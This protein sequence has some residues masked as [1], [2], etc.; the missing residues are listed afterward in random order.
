MPCTAMAACS[1]FAP[2]RTAAGPAAAVTRDASG[3]A[4]DRHPRPRNARRGSRSR[5]RSAR[6]AKPW[7]PRRIRLQ[8]RRD[9]AR[10]AISPCPGSA[11][12]R[13]RGWPSRAKTAPAR[14]SCWTGGAA[15][16]SAGI[17]SAAA[18][19]ERAAAA[20]RRLLSG[21]RAGA[22][23][24]NRTRAPSASCWRSM[25]RCCSW[26][27]SARSPAAT[28]DAVKKF[29]SNGGVLIR[30]AG[31][32]MTSGADDLVPVKLRVGGR[33]LGSAMAWAAPQHLAPL[34][35]HQPVQRPGRPRR[36]DGVAA[37]A[38]RAR[39]SNWQTAAWARLADG[40][41]LV[42]AQAARARAG[43]C[44]STSPPAPAWSSLPLSGLYVDMLQ[45]AA[46]LVGRHAGRAN[47]RG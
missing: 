19:G 42:T 30:F 11:Q 38:G 24:R 6:A 16:R 3:F 36:G 31:E 25:S 44:C 4:A 9:H 35:R 2:R 29:V 34:R 7:P 17:V 26:P 1:V 8:A 18:S 37:G 12:R 45:A 33:Y 28:I 47:W 39:R 5:A 20:V 22:L 27:M 21:A 41:P 40:T 43:S 13:P 10:M 15:Q 14:C 23:C 32:R 46:G